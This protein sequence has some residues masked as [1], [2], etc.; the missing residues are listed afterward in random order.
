MSSTECKKRFVD[1]SDQSSWAWPAKDPTKEDIHSRMAMLLEIS[2]K[3]F[4]RS[5]VYTFGGDCYIQ[6]DGGPIG[7]RLT[8]SVARLVLQDWYE[9]FQSILSCSNITKHLQGL[10]VDDGR[11]ITDILQLGTR[12]DPENIKFTHK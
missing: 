6:V 5:F 4:F 8:M 9:D 12:F 11:T 2:V 1:R 3:F 7:A 10:Y